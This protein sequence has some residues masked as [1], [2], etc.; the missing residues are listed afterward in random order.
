MFTANEHNV[1]EYGVFVDGVEQD[2][3]PDMITRIAPA[4]GQEIA[5]YTSATQE[6]V[7]RAI[8]AARREF[9]GGAWSTFSGK[10]RARV[11][12]S[13]ANLLRRD[14]E[15]LARIEAVEV[16]KPIKLARGDIAESIDLTEYAASLALNMHGE[17]YS[18]FGPDFTAMVLREPVGV[19]GMIT[20]WNFPLLVLFHKLPFA[21]GAGCTVVCKPSEFTSG[22]TIEAAKLAVEA[23][24]PAGAFSVITGTGPDVGEP[25]VK[26]PRV[27][28]VSFTG[29]SRVGRQIVQA[30]QGNV[31]RV[32]LELGGKGASVVFADADLD[33][34]VDGVLFANTFNQGECCVAG[35]R[36]LVHDDIADEFVERLAKRVKALLIG[37]PLDEGAEIG[38]LIHEQHLNKVL[39][40]AEGAI[41]DG[42]RL[43]VGGKRLADPE[44]SNGFYLEPTII[45]DVDPGTDLFT[46]EVFGP[47]LSV[48]RFRTDAEAVR[49]A[50][51]VEY[52]LANSIWTK[53][54]DRALRVSRSIRSGT[55]WVNT[56]IDGAPQLPQGGVKSSGYGREKGMAGFDEYTELKTVQIRTG[57]RG[58]FDAPGETG[59]KERL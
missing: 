5:R 11:L 58:Y 47:V 20:P 3:G 29:S 23:G 37:L 45:D 19:V 48:T 32:A 38:S 22:S 12:L 9:D 18:D 52:G 46:Q 59:K 35:T 6:D 31:K 7:E 40:Y 49:L 33:E 51:A 21:L 50:N 53:S 4:T 28:L 36:L 17:A 8:G 55:V 44:F 15:R 43:V 42:A 2:A 14:L 34:A 16:G 13:L 39:G 1:R 27:D 25:L 41:E 56:A 30:S 26:S 54:L 57:H 24:L 10:D